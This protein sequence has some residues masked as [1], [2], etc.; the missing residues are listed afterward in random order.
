MCRWSEIVNDAGVYECLDGCGDV[1]PN[2]HRRQNCRVADAALL[3]MMRYNSQFNLGDFTENILESIGVT[4]ARYIEAKKL[5][6]LS[7]TCNCELRKQWL[8]RVSDWWRGQS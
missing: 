5:F 4:K 2:R 1:S 3:G 6:G 7:P 8:N